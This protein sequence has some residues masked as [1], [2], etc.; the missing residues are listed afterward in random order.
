[1][2][3]TARCSNHQSIFLCMYQTNTLAKKMIFLSKY[4][5]SLAKQERCGQVVEQTWGRYIDSGCSM[6]EVQSLLKN[7][8][9]ALSSWSRNLVKVGM[10][11][12]KVKMNQL[13]KLQEEE[14]P[15]N[16][17]QIREIQKEVGVLLEQENAKWWQREK[18][19]IV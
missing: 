17:N 12:I 15:N 14:C 19:N 13:K 16:T 11:E 5:A 1:M 18:N 3:L 4:E 8:Y 6:R 2:S 7:C 10:E 9:E